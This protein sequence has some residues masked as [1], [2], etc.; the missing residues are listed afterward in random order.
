[1]GM[2]ACYQMIED[3]VISE[4]K[5]KDEDE[6]FE[7]VEELQE[8]GDSILDIDKLWDG[9]HC[10][11][12]GVTA[13]EPEW[14][15]PLSEAIVGSEKFIDNEDSDYISYIS[16]DGVQEIEKALMGF[17]IELAL[18]DFQPKDFVQKGIYPNI[19]IHSDKTEL[20]QELK[21]CFLE[22]RSFYEK[23]VQLKK[24]VIVSIY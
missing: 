11:L 16:S 19:W 4:L 10:L 7:N 14:G 2:I 13:S 3:S 22:L 6:L 1:M 24:G 23:A 9:L 20:K 21:E 8:D 5:K 15:N 18:I 17:D 12:T